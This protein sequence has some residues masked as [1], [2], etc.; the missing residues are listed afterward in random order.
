MGAEKVNHV[1]IS[2]K[3]I[4]WRLCAHCGLL[5]LN[6]EISRLCVKLGCEFDEK[7]AYL[8]WKRQCKRGITAT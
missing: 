2:L 3:G 6:N 4:P 8:A 7:P 1:P 5:F